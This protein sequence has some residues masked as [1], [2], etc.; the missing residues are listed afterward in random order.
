QGSAYITVGCGDAPDIR[1]FYDSI[2]LP[3]E[4]DD[5]VMRL[6]LADE[7]NPP[8]EQQ[9]GQPRVYSWTAPMVF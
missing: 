9:E 6:S 7:D 1:A 4:D 2:G 3:T 5:L 8:S